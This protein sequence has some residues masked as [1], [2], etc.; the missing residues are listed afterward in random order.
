[1]M[2]TY[3]AF[4]SIYELGYMANDLHAA[5]NESD[6][7]RRGPQ[8]AARLWVAAWV[9]FRALTFVVVTF[10]LGQLLQVAWWMF[11]IA[12]AGVFFVHNC[13]DDREMKTGT[14]A[15]LAWFR[16][17]APIVF[18]VEDSQRMGI[19]L[20][21]AMGYVAFRQLGYMDSKGLINMPGRQRH[22]FRR[23][24]FLMPLGGGVALLPY[25][26]ARGYV[27]LTLYWAIVAVIGTLLARRLR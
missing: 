19:G 24:F 1:M 6:G 26:E 11:F 9:L 2:L 18:I 3:T 13:L 27:L 8:A 20:A 17:M 15:W 5:K 22:V 16:F 4:I 23:F 10:V 21:A 7:R 14:F 25:A 12:L